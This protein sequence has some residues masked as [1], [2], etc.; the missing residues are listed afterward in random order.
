MRAP[1]LAAQL[2]AAAV[3]G[4][5][6]VL[7]WHLKRGKRP[8][9]PPAAA[10]RDVNLDIGEIVHVDA[11]NADGTA[12]CKYRG[13]NWT[14]VPGRRAPSASR[15]RTAC[16]KSSATGWSSNKSEQNRRKKLME[17]ALV[18]FVIAVIFVVRAIK[19]VPQQNAWVVERL[20][21]YHG[22]AHA[23]A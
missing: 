19:V 15:A 13:A 7:G 20:G 3:V 14:A 8:H 23:R 11:W 16:A 21:K 12:S 9:E 5:G 1:A 10:N 4:G 22:D 2:V 6:A 18:L 17:I